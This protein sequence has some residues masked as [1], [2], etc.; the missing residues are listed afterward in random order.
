[1]RLDADGSEAS[2][3]QRDLLELND[4]LGAP[5]TFGSEA[6]L[7]AAAAARAAAREASGDFSDVDDDDGAGGTG[8]RT[9]ARLAASI[10]AAHAAAQASEMG[11]SLTMENG[12][13]GEVL[14]GS[15]FVD[16]SVSQAMHSQ[17]L[18]SRWICCDVCN[19]W[20]RVPGNV[21]LP[22]D[23]EEWRCELNTWDLF[24]RCWV[25]EEPGALEPTDDEE[26][27][28]SSTH[29]QHS[30]VAGASAGHGAGLGRR[31]PADLVRGTELSAVLVAGADAIWALPKGRLVCWIDGRAYAV[32]H[33]GENLAQVS[34]HY[35]HC[36]CSK[37]IPL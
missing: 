28:G 32:A 16:S 24:N 8:R 23:D 11:N 30:K 25:D 35:D 33:S 29:D 18:Q 20:R 27:D 7:A 14:N 15:E 5:S 22:S 31:R 9:R 36:A 10:A 26:E 1:V 37:C 3:K 19:K 4:G 2:F 6:G 13:H 34:F 21:P 17:Q 12:D